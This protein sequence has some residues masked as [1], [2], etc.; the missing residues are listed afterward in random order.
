[1]T[2]LKISKKAKPE[3]KKIRG[4]A[5]LPFR[6]FKR[7]YPKGEIRIPFTELENGKVPNN[8]LLVF[9]ALNPIEAVPL[10]CGG[11]ET[12]IGLTNGDAF[13]SCTASS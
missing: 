10:S 4:A 13:D 7:N 8:R 3:N 11:S 9:Y 12:N 6:I 5:S 1:M 2:V